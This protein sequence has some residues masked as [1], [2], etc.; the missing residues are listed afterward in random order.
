MSHNNVILVNEFD[1]EIG[2]MEKLEAHQKGLLHRAFSVFIFNDKNEMLLQKRAL[3]KY[4]SGGLWT[5]TC[6][7][8]PSEN[9]SILDAGVRRLKE[10]MNYEADLHTSFSFIYKVALDNDLTE[11][12]LDHV[13]LGR[14]NENPVLNR[15]EASNY[16]WISIEDVL[17][18]LKENKN[19]Y[20]YWFNLIMSQYSNELLESLKKIS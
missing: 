20:T 14:S 12:E 10:E 19:N 11:H 6:C 16:K 2:V 4:H 13:L 5:N 17:T 18:D 8:H 7:S 9:E 15:D 3:N 1:D